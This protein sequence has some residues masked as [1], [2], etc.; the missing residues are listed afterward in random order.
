MYIYFIIKLY[1]FYTMFFI[2]IL[3]YSTSIVHSGS[4]IVQK[5]NASL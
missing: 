1:Y 2:I 4:Q 5:K 3:T